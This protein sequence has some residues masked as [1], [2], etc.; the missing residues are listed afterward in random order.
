MMRAR[1]AGF[2][3]LAIPFLTTVW[4]AAGATAEAVDTGGITQAQARAY[5]ADQGI[6]PIPENVPQ[7]ILIGNA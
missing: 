6:D 2:W 7:Q 4:P 1:I 5:L 3:M